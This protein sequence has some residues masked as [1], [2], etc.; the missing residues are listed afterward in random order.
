MTQDAIEL[1]QNYIRGYQKIL[2]TLREVH[3]VD[4]ISTPVHYAKSRKI[5]LGEIAK[6]RAFV[7]ALE[8]GNVRCA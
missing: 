5:I 8:V 3:Y 4:Q 2:R 7:R 6:A 1:H